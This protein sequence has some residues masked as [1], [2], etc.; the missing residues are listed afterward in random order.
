MEDNCS[1]CHLSSRSSSRCPQRIPASA[2]LHRLSRCR[3][4]Q[5][6][7]AIT[8]RARWMQPAGSKCWEGIHEKNN[9]WLCV[10]GSQEWGEGQSESERSRAVRRKL[11]G[12]EESEEEEKNKKVRSCP[13]PRPVLEFVR[14]GEGGREK[15]WV[16]TCLLRT[17]N[18][19]ASSPSARGGAVMSLSEGGM[20]E[21]EEEKKEWEGWDGWDSSSSPA[22]P[23]GPYLPPSLSLSLTLSLSPGPNITEWDPGNTE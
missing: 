9:R 22:A 6:L 23:S 18:K 13:R 1:A 4:G 11:K 21:A 8:T 20:H 16:N 12:A 3:P 17:S 15:S 14:G 10:E 2:D 7:S 5:K 19:S